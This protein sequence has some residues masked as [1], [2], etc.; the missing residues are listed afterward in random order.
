MAPS[1]V[2]D[3]EIAC[4]TAANSPVCTGSSGQDEDDLAEPQDIGELADAGIRELVGQDFKGHE[5]T[6][7]VTAILRAQGYI[8][9]MSRPGSVRGIDIVAGSGP[10]GFDKPR[11]CVQVKSGQGP[12][13]GTV[14]RALSGSVQNSEADYS[15]FFAVDTRP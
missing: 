1:K 6:N 5:L 10:L 8:A 14:L 7:L 4:R 3:A 12:A 15:K 9:D 2:E 13:D 11:M